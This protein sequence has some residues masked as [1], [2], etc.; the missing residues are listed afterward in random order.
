MTGTWGVISDTHG[1]LDPRV[2]GIFAGVEG[3]LHA[4]DICGEQVLEALSD[5]APVL[6]VYGNN[7]DAPLTTRLPR[8]GIWTLGGHKVMVV[9]ELKKPESPMLAVRKVIEAE[10]PRVVIF[11]HSHTPTAV[12]LDGVLYLNPGSPTV[13]RMSGVSLGVALLH[14]SSDSVSHEL[15]SL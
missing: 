10:H 13:R 3:V 12:E 14:L 15:I 5:V 6:A 8:V 2:A 9:H 4:G 11:G 1:K 7:D